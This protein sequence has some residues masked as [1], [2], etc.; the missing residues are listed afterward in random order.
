MHQPNSLET[1]A[2]KSQR[3][4]EL[5]VETTWF[6]RGS[7]GPFGEETPGEWHEAEAV[8]YDWLHLKTGHPQLSR[9]SPRGWCDFHAKRSA[10][11]DSC[12]DNDNDPHQGEENA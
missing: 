3:V 8:A 2:E 7:S 12:E 6:P 4:Q 1:A 11:D 10:D 5:G 9:L